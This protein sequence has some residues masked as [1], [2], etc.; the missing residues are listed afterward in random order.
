MNTIE[1][2]RVVT[3][4]ASALLLRSAF[5]ASN[6]DLEKAMGYDGLQKISVKG[7]DLAYARPGATLAGYNRVM[8]E[9]IDVAFSKDW[10]P[11]RTGSNIKLSAEERE[12]IRTGVAKIVYEEFV[13]ELQNKSSYQVVNEAGPDALRVKAHIVNLYVNA[14]DTKTAGRSR[15]YTVSAGEMTIFAELYD[16]ET[17]EVLARVVDRREARSSGRLTLTNSVVNASEARS[18]ASNWARILRNGL[19]KAHG[20][21]KK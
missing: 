20:I 16:S 21:G 11:T 10:N 1:S 3:L 8:L 6:A 9:P 13:K 19:D 15:T 14:P 12:N 18:I 5:A 7:I 2:V 4:L 17:G